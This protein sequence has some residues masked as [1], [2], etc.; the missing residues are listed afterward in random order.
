M[1]QYQR[2]YIL[3]LEIE[4]ESLQLCKF[5][6]S[7]PRSKQEANIQAKINER[8]TRKQ[9]LEQKIKELKLCHTAII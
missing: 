2:N 6:D 8:A 1:T 9:Y 5:S 7:V 3:R 4:L